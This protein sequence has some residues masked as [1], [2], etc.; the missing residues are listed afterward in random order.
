[1]SEEPPN[2]GFEGAQ[3]PPPKEAVWHSAKGDKPIKVIGTYGF[4]SGR[5]YLIVEGFDEPTV[6][7]DE[8]EY[9]PE[10][11]PQAEEAFEPAPAQEEIPAEKYHAIWR[12]KEVIAEPFV[13]KGVEYA[14]LETGEEVPD[15]ELEYLS[16]VEIPSSQPEP[17]EPVIASEPEIPPSGFGAMPASEHVAHAPGPP[18]VKLRHPEFGEISLTMSNG[19]LREN[20]PTRPDVVAKRMHPSVEFGGLATEESA[21]IPEPHPDAELEYKYQRA[22]EVGVLKPNGE[23]ERGW[24]VEKAERKKFTGEV[25]VIVTKDGEPTRHVPEDRIVTFEGSLLP[26]E[27]ATPDNAETAPAPAETFLFTDGQSVWFLNEDTGLYERKV[28]EKVFRGK[29]GV[30]WV[31]VTDPDNPKW[32]PRR[33]PEEALEVWQEPGEAQNAKQ[34]LWEQVPE[35]HAGMAVLAKE[36]GEQE[37]SPIYT[38]MDCF[39]REERPGT[40]FIRIRNEKTGKTRAVPHD[41]LKRWQGLDSHREADEFGYKF[42]RGEQ[43]KVAIDNQIENDWHAISSFKKRDGTIMVKI[44]RSSGGTKI[45]EVP[46]DRLLK[47]QNSKTAEGFRTDDVKVT[48]LSS[49]EVPSVFGPKGQL[50]RRRISEDN[51]HEALTKFIESSYAKGQRGLP[52][53]LGDRTLQLMKALTIPAT[54]IAGPPA[55]L[56]NKKIITPIKNKS[57]AGGNKIKATKEK[58]QRIS[59]YGFSYGFSEEEL[60][61]LMGLALERHPPQ[62]GT[63]T[64]R[65]M[66]EFNRLK[67]Q[68]LKDKGED[69]NSYRKKYFRRTLGAAAILAIVLPP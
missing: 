51:L 30:V 58:T 32:T 14:R 69:I 60:Q 31:R 29:W 9:M 68:A 54:V 45:M 2:F 36:K 37:V 43:V 42:Q 50:D 39:E 46:Q 41:V 24:R 12:G 26:P 15:S 57:A 4:R 64:I 23:V 17:A 55:R 10:A 11:M 59:A 20:D 38:V 28:A 56:M 1:M 44:M 18:Q 5:E 33:I 48:A 21:K 34:E 13:R 19:H 61:G 8:I 6:P 16:R 65:T 25:Y 67:K 3:G 49:Y 62:N 35:F 63:V 40:V 53:F 66:T 22:Q 7:A 27:E 52:A 47:W